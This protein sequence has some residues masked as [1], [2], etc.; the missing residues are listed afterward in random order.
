MLGHR[1]FL[2]MYKYHLPTMIQFSTL[3]TPGFEP[4]NPN[5]KIK[6]KWKK[7][8]NIAGTGTWTHDLK[9]FEADAKRT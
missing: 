8:F 5:H 9:H 2:S 1:S 6:K 7:K 4:P 3:P